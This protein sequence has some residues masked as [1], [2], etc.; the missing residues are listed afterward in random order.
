MAHLWLRISVAAAAI[1]LIVGMLGAARQRVI[2]PSPFPSVAVVV[3][4]RDLP[5]FSAIQP[6][7][8][9]VLYQGWSPALIGQ[10]ATPQRLIGHVLLNNVP[11]GQT[12]PTA[13][14]GPAM[15]PRSVALAVTLNPAESLAASIGPGDKVN[16]IPVCT[17]QPAQARGTLTA[18]TVLA[19]KG[20]PSSQG[21]L[22][23]SVTVVLAVP[24]DDAARDARTLLG[25]TVAISP[26]R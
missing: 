7:Q 6:S 1:V 2:Q 10:A 13:D 5:A 26:H 3:A 25:C 23:A 16:V 9:H 18:L 12:V 24:V 14:I 22:P 17:G 4:A 8:L 19:S 20:R 15:P 11:A 21:S